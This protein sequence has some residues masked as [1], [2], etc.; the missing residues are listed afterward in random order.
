VAL[1]LFLAIPS[2]SPGI[3]DPWE[4][5]LVAVLALALCPEDLDG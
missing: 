3:P 4:I 1:E 5:I 2:M